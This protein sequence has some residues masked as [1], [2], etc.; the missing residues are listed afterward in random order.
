MTVF[1]L[2]FFFFYFSFPLERCYKYIPRVVK[3]A[4]YFIGIDAPFHYF[5]AQIEVE[6]ACNPN[7]TAFDSGMGLAQ[8]M[9][10]TAEEIHKKFK[11]LQE[12]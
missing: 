7:I 12:F 3:E 8:F 1:L 9:P 11:E 6:S 4:R 2:L 10:K 5:I